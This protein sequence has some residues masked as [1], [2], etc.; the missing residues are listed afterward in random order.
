MH[1][2]LMEKERL[3]KAKLILGSRSWA[4]LYTEIQNWDQWNFVSTNSFVSTHQLK[5]RMD[6]KLNNT[7][8]QNTLVM[9]MYYGCSEANLNV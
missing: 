6:I 5:Y 3:P 7:V 1:G 9:N 4:L 2:T 8:W